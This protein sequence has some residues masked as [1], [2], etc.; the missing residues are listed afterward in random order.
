MT[1][2]GLVEVFTIT[3][4]EMQGN[5]FY[6]L[7]AKKYMHKAKPGS[8]EEKQAVFYRNL[9]QIEAAGQLDDILDTGMF[10]DHIKA[11]ASLAMKRAE[12]DSETQQ[13]VLSNLSAVFDDYTAAEALEIDQKRR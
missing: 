7:M 5:S 8:W 1:E 11:Y 6:A 4:E 12:L 9:A 2:K 10:N 3:K 13:K